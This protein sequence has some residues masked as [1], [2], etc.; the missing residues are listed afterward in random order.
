MS[1]Y[2]SGTNRHKTE[3]FVMAV[4]IPCGKTFPGNFSIIPPSKKWVFYA[5]FR[6]AYFG[7]IWRQ[8]ML[9]ESFGPD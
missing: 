8:G 5:I 1:F 9:N 3:L 2:S 7:A 4:R 6:L